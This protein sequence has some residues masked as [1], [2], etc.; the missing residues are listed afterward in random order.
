[1]SEVYK[2]ILAS[3]DN[4][5]CICCTHFD[6][7]NQLKKFKLKQSEYFTFYNHELKLNGL[8]RIDFN[9]NQ[10]II[11]DILFYNN[12][13]QYVDLDIFETRNKKK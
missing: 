5:K 6:T 1:M 12:C 3:P 2:K 7:N 13:D 11:N 10:D 4:F 9:K 8:I